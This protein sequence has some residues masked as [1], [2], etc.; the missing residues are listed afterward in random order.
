MQLSKNR[1]DTRTLLGGLLLELAEVDIKRRAYPEAAEDAL[2]I[3]RAVP[4]A[5][6]G[7]ACFDAAR[8][9]AR[10]VAL[11]GADPRLV[12]ADRERLTRPYLGRSI[13]LLREAVDSNPRMAGHQGRP[14]HQGP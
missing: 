14:G 8:I 6:R 11:V 4:E 3:P 2:R 1:S 9:L 12:P 7:E 13:V 5:G 10:L